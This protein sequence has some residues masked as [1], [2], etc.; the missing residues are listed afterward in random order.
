MDERLDLPEPEDQLSADERLHA[1]T[2][3]SDGALCPVGANGT[4]G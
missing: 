4:R 2:A 3:G 1:L